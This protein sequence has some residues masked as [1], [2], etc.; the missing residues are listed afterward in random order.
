MNQQP[1]EHGGFRLRSYAHRSTGDCRSVS[2]AIEEYALGIA[3]AAQCAVI[4]RHVLHCADCA[5]L[6]SSYSQTSAVL[7]LAVPL[8]TP[9]ASARTA[10][11]DRIAVTSQATFPARNVYAGSLDDLRT[12]TLPSSAQVA[13]LPSQPEKQSAWWH[14]YAAPLATLP[15]LLALGLVAA[16][17]FNNYSQLNDT[18]QDLAQRDLQIARLNS[19]LD[20]DNGQGVA[21]LLA[22]QSAKRYTL[23]SDGS[24][25]VFAQGMLVADP[26][27]EQAALQVSGLAP[28]TYSVVVQLQ[29]GKMVPTTEFDVGTTGSGSTLVNLG[30][31]IDDLKSVHIRPTTT[32]TETDMAGITAQPDALMTQ[33]GPDISDDSDTSVQKP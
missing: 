3:D 4:E 25:G 24:S 9:P 29:N 27:S 33:I 16:W 21:Q 1:A 20:N 14:V 2:D 28:G 10:L 17:G 11:M 18:Q 12:P 6:V 31:P 13:P 5:A 26:Q 19:Q 32:V 8:A 22:S 30:T 15:L 7:A 23:T